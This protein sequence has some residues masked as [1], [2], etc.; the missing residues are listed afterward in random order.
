MKTTKALFLVAVLAGCARTERAFVQDG[1][2]IILPVQQ[3]H[4]GQGNLV[5]MAYNDGGTKK[6][7]ITD[8]AGKSFD[9]YFDHRIGTEHPGSIW[10]DSYPGA[11]N[12]VRVIDAQSFRRL[13][14]DDPNNSM[15]RP[16]PTPRR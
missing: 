12:S 15:Q 13:V 1:V 7:T 16:G 14:I 10:L 9:V 3:E 8:S 4:D 2:R 11:S 6:I 5:L